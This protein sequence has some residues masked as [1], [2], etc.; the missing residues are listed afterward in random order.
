LQLRRN[1][2]ENHID[3]VLS[4]CTQRQIMQR[5]FWLLCYVVFFMR[6]C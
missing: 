5:K 1:L 2:P 3:I 4:L 6:R